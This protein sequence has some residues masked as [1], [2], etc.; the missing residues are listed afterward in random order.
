MGL[1]DLRG[2]EDEPAVQRL[3]AVAQSARAPDDAAPIGWEEA[4][5]VIACAVVSRRGEALEIHAI[6]VAPD[7]DDRVER[8]L[9]EALAASANGAR[10]VAETDASGVQLYRD[11]GFDVQALPADG[12][13]RCELRLEATPD[14]EATRAVTLGELEDAIARAW[15]A[16][17]A[18]DP[19]TWSPDNPARNHCDETALLV[20]ELLGG[21]ILI[22]NVVRDGRRLERHAWNRLPSGI[23]IDLTRSQFR[24]GE[25]FSTPEIAEPL[26]LQRD[27]G[28]YELFASRVLRRLKAGDGEREHRRDVHRE[29]GERQQ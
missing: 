9:V 18:D 11:C 12:R 2:R 20:R 21:E 4:G 29:D 19:A 25:E 3:V 5:D 23:S 8:A 22:A 16:E 24:D 17:T 13:F 15:S 27:R 7:G 28:R 1:V 10:L 26:R 6:V 14:F